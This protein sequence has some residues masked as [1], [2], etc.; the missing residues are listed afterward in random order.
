MNIGSFDTVLPA[1]R[2]AGTLKNRVTISNM[3]DESVVN[4]QFI[5]TTCMTPKV[6]FI[7]YRERT[8]LLSEMLKNI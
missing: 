2:N 8:L 5:P 3:N 7:R 6:S 4:F 1:Q